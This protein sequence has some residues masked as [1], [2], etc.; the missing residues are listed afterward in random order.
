MVTPAPPKTVGPDGASVDSI[1]TA[2]YQS[3]SCGP[4]VEPN[5]DRLRALFLPGAMILPPRRNAESPYAA[6]D[7]A[8][9]QDRVR[10]LLESWKQKGESTALYESEIARRE[11][12]FGNVCQVFSTFETRH[13]PS[14]ETPLYRG[15]HSLQLVRDG[16]RWRIASLVWDGER[17]GNPIPPEY[18]AK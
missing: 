9:F 2:L 6:L 17:A 3:V 13:A 14:D 11:D 10:R 18:G 4:E 15:I 7:A 5:W 12:C 1:V 16:S 8:A